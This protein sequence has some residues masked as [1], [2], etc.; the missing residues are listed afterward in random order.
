ML[1]NAFALQLDEL[2]RL[3]DRLLER[4]RLIHHDVQRQLYR[5]AQHRPM[6]DDRKIAEI[7]HALLPRHAH[8]PIVQKRRETQAM[9]GVQVRKKDRVYIQRVDSG[10]QHLHNRCRA[11]VDQ[12]A[13]VDQIAGIVVVCGNMPIGGAQN[14]KRRHLFFLLK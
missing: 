7:A 13:I 8:H 6:S 14:A 5:T 10:V 3:Y 4:L 1:V 9:V 2:R 12:R 11:R